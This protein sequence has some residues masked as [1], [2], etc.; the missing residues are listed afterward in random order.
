MHKNN[1]LHFT[2]K[3]PRPYPLRNERI[4]TPRARTNYGRSALAYHV[5]TV[6]NRV[7]SKVSFNVP[8]LKL[9]SQIRIFLQNK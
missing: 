9:I 6:I 8:L 3:I 5:P 4:L 2:H 7:A 1:L